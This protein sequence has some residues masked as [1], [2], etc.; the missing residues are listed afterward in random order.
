MG[1]EATFYAGA[2]FCVMAL[3]GLLHQS[4]RG[5]WLSTR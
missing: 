2:L 5:T 4:P 3:A 1:A